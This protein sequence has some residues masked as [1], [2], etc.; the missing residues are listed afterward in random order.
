M[1]LLRKVFGRPL[2]IVP[3]TMPPPVKPIDREYI[4]RK[5]ELDLEVQALMSLASAQAQH[6][7]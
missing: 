3:L 5:E 2:P 1:A 7:R 4:R 6:E